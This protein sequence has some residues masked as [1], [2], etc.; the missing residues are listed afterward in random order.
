[1][2]FIATSRDEQNAA[3]LDPWSVVH[4]AAGLA[5]SLVGVSPG[6]GFGAA[7]AY[8]ALELYGESRPGGTVRKIFLT[9]GPE[10]VPNIAA[11]LALFALGL[12]LGHRWIRTGPGEDDAGWR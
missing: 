9:Q 11:D 2:K 5:T 6:V 12:S 7:V 1:M 3:V 4:L 8:E 10:S